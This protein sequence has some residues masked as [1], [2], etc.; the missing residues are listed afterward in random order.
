MSHRRC[1]QVDRSSTFNESDQNAKRF[2]LIVFCVRFIWMWMCDAHRRN[3][4]RKVSFSAVACVRI[5]AHGCR[6]RECEYRLCAAVRAL[7]HGNQHNG[8]GFFEF[9][10]LCGHRDQLTFLGI[11]RRHLGTS[12]SAARIARWK[13]YLRYAFRILGEYF[14][15][16][17]NAFIGRNFVSTQFTIRFWWKLPGRK[18]KRNRREEEGKRKS[19]IKQCGTRKRIK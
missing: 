18:K 2:K 4:P 7:R 6:R 11:S 16:H 12:Q 14:D 8:A 3:R 15:A 13:F 19:R 9:G 17:F 1:H 10:R 5:R